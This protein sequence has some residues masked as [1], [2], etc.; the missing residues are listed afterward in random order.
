MQSMQLGKMAQLGLKQ[1]LLL[2]NIVV[3]FVDSGVG[4][5]PDDES[6]I[7]D[8]MFTT[9]SF[10]SGLGLTICKMI[11]DQ[12]GGKLDYRSTPSTFSVFLPKT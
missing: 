7:F 5:P 4:V 9:K 2:K 12:H 1:Q 8:P 6:K 3:Q 11:V 10:G